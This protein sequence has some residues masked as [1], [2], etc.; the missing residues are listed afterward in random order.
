MPRGRPAPR[1]EIVPDFVWGSRLISRL[2][3]YVMHGGK[4]TVAEKIV[5]GA[6][7]RIQERTNENPLDIYERALRNLM[8]TLE[9]RPRRV[10]GHIYQIPI[11]VRA[12]R[13]I[14]LAT[15]WLVRSARSRPGRTAREKL[16]DEI[17]DAAEATGG[18][19]R[20][21]E[22]MHRMAEANRAFAHYRW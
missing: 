2:I 12:S 17:L 22:D 7:Q 18:A 9:V 6:L 21:K 14:T 5:Y 19:M 4:K 3:G 8:P 10:G 11:E 1:R 15:R 20:T 13:K 16:A